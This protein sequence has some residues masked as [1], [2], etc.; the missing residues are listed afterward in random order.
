MSK[1]RLQNQS[2]PDTEHSVKKKRNLDLHVTP[3]AASTMIGADSIPVAFG[4]LPVT[5]S[6]LLAR[7]NEYVGTDDGEMPVHAYVNADAVKLFQQVKVFSPY[8]AMY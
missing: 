2:F 5:D 1:K 4:R 3:G 7:L 6:K 8:K